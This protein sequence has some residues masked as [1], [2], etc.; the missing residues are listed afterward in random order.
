MS[1]IALNCPTG[2]VIRKKDTDSSNSSG[3]NFEYYDHLTNSVQSQMVYSQIVKFATKYLFR[4]QLISNNL[5]KSSTALY[6]SV[7]VSVI[8]DEYV[9]HR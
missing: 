2:K 3:S 5:R 6:A 8:D 9:A 7:S 4:M 1:W